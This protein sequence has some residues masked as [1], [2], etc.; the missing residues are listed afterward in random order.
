MADEIKSLGGD[1]LLADFQF[2]YEAFRVQF[3]DDWK[4]EIEDA[5]EKNHYEFHLG[6][7]QAAMLTVPMKEANA[8]NGCAMNYEWEGSVEAVS[9]HRGHVQVAVLDCENAMRRYVLFT[10][11]V[12]TM[13]KQENVIGLYRYPKVYRAEDFI[14][15]AEIMKKEDIP[16]LLW[17]HIG[18]HQDAAGL[19]NCYTYGME[20][21]G[22]EEMEILH[23]KA[24]V[25]DMYQ[26]MIQLAKWV[27]SMDQTLT[28][29][30][31]IAFGENEVYRVE[32]SEAVA[33]DGTTLK[34]NYK[35]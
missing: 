27:I 19:W 12:S 9:A 11:I 17:V 5:P 21:F 29:D 28:P 15:Q 24:H 3:F 30:Q 8:V 2:D 31:G 7:V 10:M 6:D 4:V 16:I 32:R 34:I 26:F 22:K 23:C 20:D 25:L 35:N 1:V 13:M 33:Y 18:L 14:E